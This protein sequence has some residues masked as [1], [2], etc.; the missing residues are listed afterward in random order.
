LIHE[1]LIVDV[2]ML[3][4]LMKMAEVLVGIPV[5]VRPLALEVDCSSARAQEVVELD[6]EALPRNRQRAVAVLR[7]PIKSLSD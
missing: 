4:L 7:V 5:N 2:E 3:F 1:A 6:G